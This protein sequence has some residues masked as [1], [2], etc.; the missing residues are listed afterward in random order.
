MV[1]QTPTRTLQNLLHPKEVRYQKVLIPSRPTLGSEKHPSVSV[2][3]TISS[4]QRWPPRQQMGPART[5]WLLLPQNRRDARPLPVAFEPIEKPISL[6]ASIS[7][8]VGGNRCTKYVRP[9]PGSNA[10][11]VADAASIRAAPGNVGHGPSLAAD[12]Q[13]PDVEHRT[14]RYGPALVNAERLHR[15]APATHISPLPAAGEGANGFRQ[16]FAACSQLGALT[17]RHL[18]LQ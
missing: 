11:P 5:K 17:P 6:V 1:N 18:L 8:L 3:N 16:S 10:A 15:V 2:P 4:R 7:V 9:S 12:F 14:G 13:R